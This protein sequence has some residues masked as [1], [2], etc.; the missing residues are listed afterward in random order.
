MAMPVADELGV[1]VDGE[2]LAGAEPA[3]ELE[4]L[5]LPH[6]ATIKATLANAATPPIRCLVVI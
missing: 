3:V 1:L 6:A 2:E 4:L 5:L